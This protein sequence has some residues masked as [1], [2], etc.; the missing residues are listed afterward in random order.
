MP[1]SAE[2]AY[3]PGAEIG[4]IVR[5]AGVSGI[6]FTTFTFYDGRRNAAL[7][8]ARSDVT[9]RISEVAAVLHTDIGEVEREHE[10]EV[11]QLIRRIERLES[12]L[13]ER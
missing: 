9:N 7:A 11:D 1:K 12:L 8:E 3:L 4:Q 5:F 10:R 13:L 2:T 6:A